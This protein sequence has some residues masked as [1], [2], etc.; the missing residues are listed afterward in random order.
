[1]FD[2]LKSLLGGA[3][4][5]EAA[6]TVDVDL[7]V[8]TVVVPGKNALRE[9]ERL[10]ERPGVSAV[11]MGEA[12]DVSLLRELLDEPGESPYQVLARAA[13]LDVEA[14]LRE[15][16]SGDEEYF[17]PAR[18]PWP[19]GAAAKSELSLHIG[20]LTR[21]PKSQVI[22]GLFPT[23]NPWEVPA[24]VRHGGWNE[25]PEAHVQVALHKRW[26]DAYGARIA[27][28]SSDIIECTV[29]R[30]PATR[31]AALALAREQFLYCPDIVHQGCESIEGL[32]A[33]LVGNPVWYFWWD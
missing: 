22:I 17:Q 16:A 24:Y 11:I 19:D 1:M 26:H 21:R 7:P 32:A 29:E 25:C 14:W 23:G 33:T 9:R 13:S 4:D 6:A 18:V 8:E 2:F 31:E 27:C 3:R 10:A 5:G 28:M 12:E 30:P 15:R 20:V